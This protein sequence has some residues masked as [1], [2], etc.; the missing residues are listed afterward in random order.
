MRPWPVFDSI[1]HTYPDEAELR[2]V[3]ETRT[4]DLLIPSEWH[5]FAEATPIVFGEANPVRGTV[6]R[7]KWHGLE[8]SAS[9]N[10]VCRTQH[11]DKA[12]H[13]RGR[14]TARDAAVRLLRRHEHAQV[15][16]RVLLCLPLRED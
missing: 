16:V 9:G 13:A 12:G 6:A 14:H 10:R 11:S 8:M 3:H 4:A 7:P 15:H 1:E 2:I 5:Q